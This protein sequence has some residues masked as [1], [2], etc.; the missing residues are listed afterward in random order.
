MRHRP[1]LEA[2]HGIVDVLILQARIL[3]RG[4]GA[5]CEEDI[6]PSPI[7]FDEF[8][9]GRESMSGQANLLVLLACK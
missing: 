2:A 6:I 9:L 8:E 5:V 1:F 4:G 3:H 7:T